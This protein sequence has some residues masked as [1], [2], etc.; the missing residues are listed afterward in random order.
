MAL[1]LT[2]RVQGHSSATAENGDG[3]A[4]L[5]SALR[6][7]DAAVGA[8]HAAMLPNTLLMVFTGQV[9]QSI[10]IQNNDMEDW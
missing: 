5:D 10:V 4:A 3:E 1:T 9:I 7:L 8:L 6:R 2:A